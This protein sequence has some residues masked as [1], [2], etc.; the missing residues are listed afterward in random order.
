MYEICMKFIFQ[1]CMFYN[2]NFQSPIVL[3][4]ENIVNEQ[5]ESEMK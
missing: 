3:V 5:K 4:I 2:M 1:V